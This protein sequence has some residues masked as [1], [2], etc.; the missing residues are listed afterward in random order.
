MVLQNF[1]IWI[2]MEEKEKISK[3]NSTVSVIED[4]LH[5]RIKKYTV[6]RSIHAASNYY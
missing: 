4:Y 2:K 1:E 5:L 6:E 3:M